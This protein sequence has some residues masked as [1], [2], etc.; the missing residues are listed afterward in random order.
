MK[1]LKK[2]YLALILFF[3]YAPIVVLIVF[4]FNSSKSRAK[5]S[6]FTFDW[7]LELFSDKNIL[8]AFYTTIAI[9]ITS[10]LIATIIGTFAAIGINKM[11]KSLRKIILSLNKLPIINPDIVTGVSLMILFLSIFKIIGN[12][13]QLGFSTLLLSN[14]VFNIPYV[15]LAVLPVLK[16]LN[17]NIYE[18]AIDLGAT[19]MQAFLKV[20]F[21]VIMP[22]IITGAL[23]AFTL[24]IDDFVISY[25]TTGSGVNTLS[26]SIYTMT[27]RGINPTINALSTIMFVAVMLLLFL[28]NKR[29]TNKGGKGDSIL[30]EN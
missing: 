15:I 12:N 11:N 13:G 21:P 7:Y 18:A 29:E 16:N 22:S 5:F 30:N 14:T 3:L 4:S 25:F 27:K 1:G 23:L 17:E 20:I 2:L 26:I 19:P 24:S 10:A 9:A 28:I 6:G 8:N